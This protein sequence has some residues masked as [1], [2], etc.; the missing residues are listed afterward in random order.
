MSLE[1]ARPTSGRTPRG[2]A[3]ACACATLALPGALSIP[4]S[5]APLAWL[6]YLGCRLWKA[7]KISLRSP[8]CQESPWH[9]ARELAVKTLNEAT[10]ANMGRRRAPRS[11]GRWVTPSCPPPWS[12]PRLNT[13]RPPPTLA[14]LAAPC[15][16]QAAEGSLTGRCP[17]QGG[18]GGR[19]AGYTR[20]P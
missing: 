4:L 10:W 1:R 12:P 2:G 8:G 6:G 5:R 3:S 14:V 15:Q 7:E 9:Q 17:T 13:H 18:G 16:R 11:G 19:R 20:R